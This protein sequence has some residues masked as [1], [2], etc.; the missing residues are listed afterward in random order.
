M[1]RVKF[2]LIALSVVFNRL[3]NPLGGAPLDRMPRVSAIF[4]E[5]SFAPHFPTERQLVH[6]LGPGV[7][8]HIGNSSYR[9]YRHASSSLWVGCRIDEENRV[10]RPITGIIVS[11]TPIGDS[12]RVPFVKFEFPCFSVNGVRIGDSAADVLSKCGEPLRIYSGPLT[13]AVDATIYEF[14]PRSKEAGSCF[15]FYFLDNRVAAMSFSSEE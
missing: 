2:A 8:S 4:C 6:E 14:F 10:E 15:R 9:I 11:N 3:A 5:E 7:L 1:G 12:L 13:K